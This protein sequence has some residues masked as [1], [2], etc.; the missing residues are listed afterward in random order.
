MHLN[1]ITALVLIPLFIQM[2]A[3]LP[4][5]A[6]TSGRGAADARDFTIKL[7]GVDG[8]TY[9]VAEMRGEVVIVSFGATWCAP[10][11]W[12][13]R[14]IEEL[15]EEYREKPVKF[16]WVSIEPERDASD[17]LLKRY[18]KSLR[19]TVPVLRDATREA[20][21]QFS[22]R[23]RVPMVILFDRE[24]RF[25]APAHRGMTSDITGYK[26][27]MRGRINQLLTTPSSTPGSATK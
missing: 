8:K 10:C 6:Q 25:A 7:K 13:L 1:R 22:D 21:A 27:F 16:L 5:A 12:E 9:D 20:F 26:V 4:V 2:A 24:G 11:A 23:V 3:A 18:A 15:K 19:L 17:A 14:A